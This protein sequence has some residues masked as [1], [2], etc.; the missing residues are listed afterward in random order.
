MSMIVFISVLN[1][2]CRVWN[3][4]CTDVKIRTWIIKSKIVEG[5]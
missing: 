4:P 2:K 5:I 3:Q 1:N